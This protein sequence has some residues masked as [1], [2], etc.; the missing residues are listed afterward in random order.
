METHGPNKHRHLGAYKVAMLL[1]QVKTQ[2]EELASQVE[3]LKGQ[4]QSVKTHSANQEEKVKE[5]TVKLE[6]QSKETE[7]LYHQMEDMDSVLKSSRRECETLQQR[8]KYFNGIIVQEAAMRQHNQDIKNVLFN[9]LSRVRKQ[10]D[11]ERSLTNTFM[12][13]EK[14]AQKELEELHDVL[15]KVKSVQDEY[16]NKI[17]ELVTEVEEV[18][19]ECKVEKDKNADLLRELE[20]IKVS[21]KNNPRYETKNMLET[22]KNDTLQTQLKQENIIHAD[23]LLADLDLVRKMKA[24]RQQL[25]E[26]KKQIHILQRNASEM[27]RSFITELEDF[28]SQIKKI[29]STNLTLAANTEAEDKDPQDF[30]QE[31]TKLKVDVLK[32]EKASVPDSQVSDFLEEARVPEENLSTTTKKPTTWKR[33]CCCMGLKKKKKI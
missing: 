6:E 26:M 19:A 16:E 9:Q 30:G 15:N 12:A 18:K 11:E 27:E 7:S 21:Y 3:E 31:A 24:V 14:K 22:G 8:I 13:A 25:Q 10:L 1:M 17:N 2:K 33:L 32:Q 5:L 29:A 28:R 4:L 20:E 23:S